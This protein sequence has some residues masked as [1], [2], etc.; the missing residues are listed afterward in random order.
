MKDQQL[1]GM[2]I[3]IYKS[4]KAGYGRPEWQEWITLPL[5]SLKGYQWKEMYSL[6][7]RALMLIDPLFWQ[8]LGKAEGWTCDDDGECENEVCLGK[9]GWK[10]MWHRFIDHIIEGKPIDD[11]FTTL[12][13]VTK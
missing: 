3:A 7:S 11:F 5:L 6:T 1:Q 4:I 13:S 2:D 8:S 12:L 9:D 10:I